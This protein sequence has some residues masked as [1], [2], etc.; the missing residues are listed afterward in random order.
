MR[1][2]GHAVL[3]E[4]R[5][6]EVPV[7]LRLG[8]GQRGEDARRQAE[9]EADAEHVASPDPGSC[10]RRR[11]DESCSRE[12]AGSSCSRRRRAARHVVGH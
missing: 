12:S 2:V 7:L 3:G 1:Q 9:V 10:Q 6:D 5:R 8:R 11:A 4:Q